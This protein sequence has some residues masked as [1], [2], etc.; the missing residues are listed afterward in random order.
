[1]LVWSR[2]ET[3]KK[4]TQGYMLNPDGHRFEI[5]LISYVS[6]SPMPAYAG[7]IHVETK[8]QRDKSVKIMT[9][10]YFLEGDSMKHGDNVK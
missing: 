9:P 1:M 8:P 5:N 4:V 3:L 7:S 2:T 6:A 10:S